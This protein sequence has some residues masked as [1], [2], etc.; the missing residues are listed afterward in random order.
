MKKKYLFL[1]Y[2]CAPVI[3][4]LIGF[5]VFVHILKISLFLSICPHLLIS[6][7]GILL[8]SVIEIAI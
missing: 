7:L 5:P 4:V 2:T 6:G 1:K 3:C 8:T